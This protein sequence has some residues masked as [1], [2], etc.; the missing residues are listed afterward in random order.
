MLGSEGEVGTK[1][2]SRKTGLHAAQQAEALV[3]DSAERK[4]PPQPWYD[5]VLDC[6]EGLFLVGRC[7]AGRFRGCA[8]REYGVGEDGGCSRGIGWEMEREGQQLG[9]EAV[10]AVR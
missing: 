5:R 6:W 8:V 3:G 7:S 4:T 2:E 10:S 1:T 9:G